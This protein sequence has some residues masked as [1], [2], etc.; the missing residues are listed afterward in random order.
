VSWVWQLKFENGHRT[1]GFAP[2]NQ[3]GSVFSEKISPNDLQPGDALNSTTT[4]RSLQH[5]ILFTGWAD[6]A[7]GMI[8][9]MEE[10]NC[11]ADLVV[12]TSR[13]MAIEGNGSVWVAGKQ[14][15]PIRKIGVQ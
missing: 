6:K 11:S 3:E 5:I 8:K 7:N 1:W 15:W 12:H 2:F 4:D 13:K 9:T 14:Y 10:Q